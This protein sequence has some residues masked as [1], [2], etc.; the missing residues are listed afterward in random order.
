MSKHSRFKKMKITK[1][2]VVILSLLVLTGVGGWL[3]PILINHY[4]RSAA[5]SREKQFESKRVEAQDLRV[6]GQ[7]DEAVKKVDEALRDPSLTD[8]Q[9]YG[10]YI[11]RGNVPFDQK[12][13]AAAIGFYEKAEAI[14]RD[15]Q[16]TE[17]L[18]LAWEYAGNKEKAIEY[19][20]KA[21]ELIPQDTPMARDL[22]SDLEKSILRL[23]GTL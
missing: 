9:R 3:T 14:K 8:E 21:I 4:Q 19:Y 10:L 18:A 5:E 2:T 20:K 7:T 22:K 23:G 16:V 15:Y 12:D 6:K 1:K 13:Y 17:V 11:E